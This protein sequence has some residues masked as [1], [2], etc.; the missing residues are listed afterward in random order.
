MGMGKGI[1]WCR[2]HGQGTTLAI[3]ATGPFRVVTMKGRLAGALLVTIASWYSPRAVVAQDALVLSGG[4]ARGLAHVGALTHLGSLHYDP[5]IVVGTSMGAVVGALYAAG[6]DP[7]ELQRRVLSVRWSEMFLPTPMVVGPNRALRFPAVSFDL[8]AT[9]RRVSRG[10]FGQW[11]VN[12]E[13][14][15]LLF[16]ANARSRGDF[17]RLPRRFRAITADLQT[18][19]QVVLDSGDLA[20]AVRASMAYPGF[21]APVVWGERVLVDGGIANNF[22]TA[23]ARRMGAAR[24]VG[25]DVSRPPREIGSMAPL[26]VINRSIS[27]MQQNLERDTVPPDGLITPREEDVYVGPSFPD[28]PLPVIEAGRRAALRDLPSLRPTKRT[29]DPAP[30]RPPGPF[31]ALIVDAPDPAL[32]A[33]ARHAFRRVL[34]RPYDPDAVAAAIDQLF[35]TGLFEGVWPRT[36]PASDSTL[37]LRLDPPAHSSLSIGAF[38]ENDRGGNAWGSL[39]RRTHLGSQSLV[40][41][42]AGSAGGLERWATVSGQ[43]RFPAVPLLAWSTGAHV[44][45]NSS[46]IFVDD[47]RTTIETVRAGG[48]LALEF[49]HFLRKHLISASA[50]AE[51]INVEDGVQ[52]SSYGPLF[53]FVSLAH[54]SNRVGVPLLLELEQRWGTVG[55]SR[56]AA[57][58]SFTLGSSDG[59]QVAPVIDVRLV[60]HD[61]PIDVQPALG[62][63]H[64]VPGLRW[65]ELRGD[66][67]F[68]AGFAAGVPIGS[69][70]LRLRIAS[71]VI[72]DDPND[73][74]SARWTSGA[75]L[76]LLWSTQIGDLEVG[77]GH[78][79]RG[80]GR[81]DVSI[82]RRF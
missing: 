38:Y 45:E 24:V 53:R 44:L 9:R 41:S 72:A 81:F 37:L 42:A 62:D 5:E 26:A 4:G 52:G 67:R 68:V 15:R 34:N 43:L 46:R 66:A 20:R 55:Y 10:L 6:Y 69:G 73:W 79:T 70:F 49:P 27:L 22:P 16:D 14:A 56:L 50:R 23:V 63:E 28:N 19:T 7:Q 17:N 32:R 47:G 60:S 58:A 74:G 35:S 2:P 29:S 82:G 78:A 21:F 13:L 54:A 30:A 39:E 36:T 51:N 8:D 11:R 3:R 31:T 77:Y 59:P 64:A 1:S 65:G 57:T 61:G 33:M 80:D 12:R 25:V 48:W 76:A 18:G 71:G 40:L 75:Q